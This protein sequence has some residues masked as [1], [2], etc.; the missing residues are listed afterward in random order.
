MLRSTHLELDERKYLENRHRIGQRSACT[1]AV[2][3]VLRPTDCIKHGDAIALV[4]SFCVPTVTGFDG[5]RDLSVGH[6][7]VLLRL[8]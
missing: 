7:I 4:I 2:Y 6:R 5:Y 1:S 8:G 3:G